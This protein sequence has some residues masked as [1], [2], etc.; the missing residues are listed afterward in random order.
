MK[1]PPFE[2][3]RFFRQ[4]EFSA[5]HGI[6]SSDCEPLTLPE[7]LNYAS[8]ARRPLANR[9]RH[10]VENLFATLKQFW[11]FATRYCKLA[12]TFRSM[13]CLAGWF[14][15]TRSTMGAHTKTSP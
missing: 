2:I 11:G 12:S 15:A 14:V 13:V 1:L 5:P 4:H 10:L 8:P 3:E 6:S 9:R 7:I